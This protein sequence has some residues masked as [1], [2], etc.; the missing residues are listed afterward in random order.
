[1]AKFD[2]QEWRDQYD[3]LR[4][5][6][7]KLYEER[8]GA[9]ADYEEMVNATLGD[10]L[11]ETLPAA[12]QMFD[13]AREAGELYSGEFVPAMGEYLKSAQ[14]YDTPERRASASG[15]AMAD[16]T[17]AAD[18]ARKSSLERLESYGVDPS[19]TRSAALDS[20][21]RV[22]AALDAVRAGNEASRDVEE[23]GRAYTRDALGLGGELVGAELGLS[24]SASGM[25][26][27]GVNAANTVGSTW[28]NIYGTPRQLIG[29]Q[30]GLID[31]SVA[32]K[33]AEA[34]FKAGTSG[35]SGLAG[36]GQAVGTVGGAVAGAYFGAGNP[37]AI[38][39]G[40]SA[41]GAAGGAIGGMADGG[42]GGGG[43]ASGFGTIY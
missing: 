29:D 18:A 31:A 6:I 8:K 20:G 22:N 3:D 35:G 7:Q 32:A 33:Q 10:L 21:I 19:M 25:L 37:A 12:K 41:G 38:S 42:G 2:T 23:R 27:S 39:A 40:A 5:R 9:T 11:G 17:T 30:K 16:V 24:G 1:M 4:G 34:N 13:Q 43:S 28:T 15:R 26:T 36:I 14:E